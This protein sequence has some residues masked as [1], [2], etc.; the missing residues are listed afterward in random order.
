MLSFLLWFSTKSSSITPT[1]FNLSILLLSF[2][3]LWENF[4]L[5]SV[6]NNSEQA[7][8]LYSFV[9]TLSSISNLQN[10]VYCLTQSARNEVESNE[11]AEDLDQN[12]ACNY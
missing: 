9:L 3:V 7:V 6:E 11:C 5:V 10:L 8:Q 1:F 12:K 2:H 4:E